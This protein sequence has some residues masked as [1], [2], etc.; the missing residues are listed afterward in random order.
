MRKVWVIAVREYLAAVRSKSFIVGIAIMPLIMSAGF[1]AQVLLKDQ[2]DLRPKQFAVIDR[3]PGEQIWAKLEVAAKIRNLQVAGQEGEKPKG[4]P[5]LLERIPAPPDEEMAEARLHLSQRVR[6]GDLIGFLE[7]GP[8][9]LESPPGGVVP[10]ALLAQS[11][12]ATNFFK[13]PPPELEPYALRYQ[14]NRASYQDFSKWAEAAVKVA[15]RE[16]RGTQLNI[17]VIDLTAVLQ[18]VLLINKG[19]TTR[20]PQTGEIE[21]AA[22][23]NPIVAILL[24]GGLIVLMFLLIMLGAAPLLQGVIEEKMQRIA[25]VLLGS[26]QPFGLMMGKVIGMVGVSLTMGS[27]YIGGAYWAVQH[28]GYAEYLSAEIVAWFLVYQVLAVLMFGSIYAAVG[29]ACTDM[30]EAQAM[31]TPITLVAMVPLFVWI[32]VVR[33]PTSAFATVISFIP[34]ATPTLMLARQA[35]PPGI[36][37][38][39]PLVGIAI[40]LATT[41]LCIYASGRIFRV[42]ILMQGKGARFGELVQWVIRG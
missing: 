34:T 37:L 31:L 25:E 42:G 29:A 15:V 11:G 27:V 20:D 17:R 23:Q 6:D 30:K 40:M 36:P 22:D 1:V 14:S 13:S 32:N 41:L 38:W 3:T 8:R 5:F 33:E 9:V 26:V 7:M 12:E 24:P 19:L 4:P 21:E 16:N 35:V 2:V 10:L 39:Q 28:F 18:P